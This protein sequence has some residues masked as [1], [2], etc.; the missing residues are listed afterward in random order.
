MKNFSILI[1]FLLISFVAYSQEKKNSLED[2]FSGVI[3]KSNNYQDY[4]VVKKVKLYSLRKNVLDSISSLKNTIFTANKTIANQRNEI[5]D[6]KKQLQSTQDSLTVSK[7]KEDGMLL[8]GSS[9]KKST[10]NTV[11]FSIIGLLV[12]AL[13]ILFFQFKSSNAITK[14]TKQKLVE[15]EE[16]FEAHRQRA[17]QRE[18]E[19]RR[20]L[21]DEINKNKGA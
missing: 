9:V 11:L 13:I 16:E 2:Q 18:Q 20:K 1:C 3:E 21:Q 19:I 10:Y 15:T 6:L 7:E 12:M 4:K 5:L 17:L 8:F 14:T